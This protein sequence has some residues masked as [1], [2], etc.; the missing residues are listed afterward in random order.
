MTRP[1]SYRR[2]GGALLAVL[3]LSAI[4]AAIAFSV[5][6]SV[7][8]ETERASTH[9]EAIRAYY[10]AVSGI[11]RALMYIELGPG[12]RNPDGSVRY[13]EPGMPRL[14]L[15]WPAGT[16][17]VE[18]LRESAKFDIN[19]VPPTDLFRLLG[20]LGANPEQA[21]EITSGILDWRNPVPGGVLSIFDRHYLSLRP[22]F[23]ARHASFE[24]IEEL[25]LVKGMTPDLFY[26]SYGRDEEGRLQPRAGLKDCVSVYGSSGA[27][28]INSVAPAVL[29]AIGFPPPVV[30]AIVERRRV[31]PFRSNAE[32]APFG[33]LAGPAF[34]RIS[35]GD[36][37]TIFALR[38]TAQLRNP[39]GGLSDL[40]RSVSAIY[41]V[42]KPGWNPPMEVL[43]WYDN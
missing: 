38:S 6:T 15:N 13:H 20:V 9:S 12:A 24:E 19:E 40:T 10:L 28:D 17:T 1:A 29:I 36:V 41:K 18:I 4:L 39:N 35:L 33:P 21:R 43:R 37:A 42:H 14:N 2:R 7:R 11:Q 30:A 22:S 23:R 34:S 27:F 31:R 25:L 3:W 32:L 26:G 5:A 8:G 16:A